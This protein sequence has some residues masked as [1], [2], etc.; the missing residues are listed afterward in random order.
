VTRRKAAAPL[1]AVLRY[2]AVAALCLIA[3]LSM[4]SVARAALP[5]QYQRQKELAAIIA[6]DEIL[7]KLGRRV[8][9]RI[10]H[11]GQDLYRISTESCSLDVRIV[12]DRDARPGFVGPRRFHL[13]IGAP[14]CR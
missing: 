14:A 3:L 6:D 13:A 1:F 12:S 7:A 4:L 11:V 8:I 9:D 10:E 2:G 5:P